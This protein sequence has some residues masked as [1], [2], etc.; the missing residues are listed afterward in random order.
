[1]YPAAG[2]AAAGNGDG[3]CSAITES[4]VTSVLPTTP[5]VQWAAVSS[6]VGLISVALQ[7]KRP[8]GV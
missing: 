7:R 8:S 2:S 1:M 3:G 5:S 4:K 6:T